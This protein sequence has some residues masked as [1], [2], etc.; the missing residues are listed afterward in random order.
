M[1]S[2][3]TLIL[4]AMELRMIA[5][6]LGRSQLDYTYDLEKNGKR[7][8]TDAYGIGVG[9]GDE[10]AGVN[11]S[12][13]LDQEFFV[14]LT[15]VYTN[16]SDDSNETAALKRIYDDLEFITRDFANTKLGAPDLVLTVQQT[17]IEEPT[18]ISDTTVAV[19]A[20]FTVKHRATISGTATLPDPVVDPTV[21]SYSFLKAF[22]CDGTSTYMSAPV[23]GIG[24]ETNITISMS[25]KMDM[26]LNNGS[27]YLWYFYAPEVDAVNSKFYGDWNNSSFNFG[28]GAARTTF[29]PTRA[30][31]LYHLVYVYDGS[32]AVH[33][34]RAKLYVDGVHLLDSNSGGTIPSTTP[35]EIID[36]NMF[37]SSRENDVFG[38]NAFSQKILDISIFSESLSQSQVTDLY[39]GGAFADPTGLASCTYSYWM[40]DNTLDTSNLIMDNIGSANMG[41]SNFDDIDIVTL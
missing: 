37:I 2:N 28:V 6:D 16:R 34:D 24:G 1:S 18:K 11:K 7:A 10:V 22:Q 29:R 8:E 13:T 33:T 17:S 25:V 32:E 14:V 20:N 19:R 31:K 9:A 27:E 36:Q 15:E 3:Q 12:L 30:D 35:V 38:A 40:G 23:R 41:C 4:E 39:N 5:L 26:T 21:E